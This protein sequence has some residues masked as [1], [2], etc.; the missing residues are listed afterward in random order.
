MVFY[1]P[2]LLVGHRIV[3]AEMNLPGDYGRN[4][5]GKL[6]LDDGTEIAVI[7]NIGCLCGS[8]DYY[9]TRLATTE[10]IITAIRI[11]DDPAGDG[12]DGTGY[13]IYVITGNDEINVLQIDGDDGNGYYG[14]G[15]WLE[16]NS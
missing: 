11:V 6:T 1:N 13:A 7:P 8:G 14:T 16:I 5:N 12:T 15:Y 10:N 9:I 2:E 3:K 4:D